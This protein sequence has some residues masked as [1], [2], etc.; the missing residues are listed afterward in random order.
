LKDPSCALVNRVDV[1]AMLL[2]GSVDPFARLN[3]LGRLN[4]IGFGAAARLIAEK[5]NAL[6][7]PGTVDTCPNVIG[8]VCDVVFYQKIQA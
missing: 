3:K 8:M 4:V 5:L 1:G 2:E 6:A 7:L